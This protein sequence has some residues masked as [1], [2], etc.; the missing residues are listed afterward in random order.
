[1]GEWDQEMVKLYQSNDIITLN[2][3]TKII[4]D[5]INH[6][7]GLIVF[8]LPAKQSCFTRTCKPLAC[9]ADFTYSITPKTVKIRTPAKVRNLSLRIWKRFC[10]RSSIGVKAR[11]L[12]TVSLTRPSKEPNNWSNGTGKRRES[13]E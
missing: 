9:K 1:M 4:V 11:S 10:A 6:G 7:S 5:K 3:G 2:K 12:A 8:H 13:P